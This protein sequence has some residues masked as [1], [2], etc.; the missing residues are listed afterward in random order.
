MY[1][2]TVPATCA[3]IGVGFD[4]TGLAVDLHNAVE[5]EAI[6]SGLIIEAD[7]KN[8][9][10]PKDKSNLIYKSAVQCADTLGKKLP[11]LHMKQIDKIPHT[12]GLGSSSACIVAGLL[13]ATTLLGENLGKQELLAIANEIEGHPDNVAPAIYGGV[14]IS[15]M[16]EGKLVSHPIP[17]KDDICVAAIVPDFTLSTKKAREVLP[18]S[19]SMADAISNTARCG[20]LVSALYSGDYSLI[21]A[22]LADRL[23]QPYRKTLITGYDEV[24]EAAKKAGAYGSCISGAGPTMLAFFSNKDKE[25][26]AKLEANLKGIEGGWTPMVMN[27]DTKGAFV[28]L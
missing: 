2:V 25:L 27:F 15:V 11:G 28:E 16:E 3:N 18:K 4:S 10:V 5:F 23:H 1:K 17:V 14:C 20:L 9:N 22:A 26:S 13:I 7:N 6:E 12:R 21:D 19:V 8:F 24:R